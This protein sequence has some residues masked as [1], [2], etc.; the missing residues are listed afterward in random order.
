VIPED[1]VRLSREDVALPEVTVLTVGSSDVV[2]M[3]P[4]ALDEIAELAVDVEAP[5]ETFPLPE[6][7]TAFAESDDD[8]GGVTDML[9]DTVELPD[10]VETSGALAE[11]P[12]EAL[13]L[14]GVAEI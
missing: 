12:E 3:D 8:P 14:P 7:E 2:L 5:E 9:T 13:E 10:G 11:A 6:E 4:V 1:V